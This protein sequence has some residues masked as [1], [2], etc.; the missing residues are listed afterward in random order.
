ML[1][2]DIPY[3]RP[4]SA[5]LTL[6]LHVPDSDTS[7][8]PLVV[9]VHGGAWISEDKADH[10]ELAARLSTATGCAVA[11]PNYSLSPRNQPTDGSE[12][13]H[14][15]THARDVLRAFEFLRTWD[16]SAADRPPYYNAQAIFA[17]GHS[18]GAHILGTILLSPSQSPSPQISPSQSLLRAVRG[19][20]T[21][22]G[23]FDIDLLLQSFPAY[24][25]WFIETAFGPRDNYRSV[26][27]THFAAR[28]TRI[29]WLLVH[30]TGDT[31][32]DQVQSSAIARN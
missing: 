19:V 11:V 7:T 26:S 3:T 14:H 32:I 4:S 28:S 30:S 21:T 9:F 20:V 31:L 24:R 13:I 5:K 29:A 25:A 8:K 17:I 23:I 18:C 12:V 22:E 10:R 6:D 1:L 27:V 15:P 2:P 16:Q